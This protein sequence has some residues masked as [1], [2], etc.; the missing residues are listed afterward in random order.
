VFAE[1]GNVGN[2]LNDRGAEMQTSAVDVEGAALPP[3]GKH[4]LNLSLIRNFTGNL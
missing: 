4:F 2:V 3:A 1:H